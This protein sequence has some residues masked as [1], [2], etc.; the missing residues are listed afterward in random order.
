MSCAYFGALVFVCDW[1]FGSSLTIT[2]AATAFRQ[3]RTMLCLRPCLTMKAGERRYRCKRT[4][5]NLEFCSCYH[6]AAKHE[7]TDKKLKSIPAMRGI[8]HNECVSQK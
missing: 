3:A 7:S 6:R 1:N 5:A 4:M 8:R 2:A